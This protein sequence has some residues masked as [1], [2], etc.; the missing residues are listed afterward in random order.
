MAEKNNATCVIC[1]K[2]YHMCIHCGDNRSASPWKLHTDTP[3]HYK[4]YKILH[5]VTSGVYTK[6]EAKEKFKNVDLSDIDSFK[7]RIKERINNIMK[8]DVAPIF[9]PHIIEN[10]SNIKVATE[11]AVIE[12]SVEESTDEHNK[13]RAYRR[14]KISEYSEDNCDE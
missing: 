7:D 10:V 14:R 6:D 4:I 1:G 8:E 2:G 13:P 9:N 5:G 12:N 11:Q 3:E